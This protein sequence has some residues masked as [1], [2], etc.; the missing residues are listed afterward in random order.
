M[1]SSSG[2]PAGVATSA[3][4]SAPAAIGRGDDGNDTGLV[5]AIRK[6]MGVGCRGRFGRIG[7]RTSLS[8]MKAKAI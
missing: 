4:T 3:S 1:V 5:G 8:L 6:R 2:S 7:L